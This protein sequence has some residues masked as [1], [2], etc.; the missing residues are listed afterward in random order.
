[1]TTR[2]TEDH[3]WV[4]LE[5]D[6]AVVGITAYAAQELGQVVYVELP[7]VGARFAQGADMAV[8]ESAKA[9]SDVYAP[10][11]G[12]VIA[13]NTSLADAPQGVSDAPEGEGWFVK[14]KLDTPSEFDALMDADA[15]KA[16]TGG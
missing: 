10:V 1:M 4:R 5:G 14:L 9:A 2:F 13:V 8:V 15:Y 3:E 7:E 16:H 6:V 12:E 11:S